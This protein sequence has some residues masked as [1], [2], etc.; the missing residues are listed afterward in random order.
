MRVKVTIWLRRIDK[1]SYK[2][3]E[4]DAPKP[5]KQNNKTSDTSTILKDAYLRFYNRVRKYDY[6]L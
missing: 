6:T 2:F 1:E 3:K 5:R 4:H